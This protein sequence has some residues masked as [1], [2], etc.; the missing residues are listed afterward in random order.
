M[1][2]TKQS[3][4]YMIEY[5]L[6]PSIILEQELFVSYDLAVERASELLAARETNM[7]RIYS[8]QVVAVVLP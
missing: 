5:C 4:S 6:D 7:V 2:E 8:L 1:L 3:E